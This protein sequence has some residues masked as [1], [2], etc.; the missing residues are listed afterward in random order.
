MRGW[1][2]VFTL[3]AVL[4]VMAAVTIAGRGHGG[5]EWLAAR[6]LPENHRVTRS[7]LQAPPEANT[8]GIH[9]PDP[10]ELEARFVGAQIPVGQAVT[11][12][13]LRAE[14]TIAPSDGDVVY[15]LPLADVKKT[16][17]SPGPGWAVDVCAVDKGCIRGTVVTVRCDASQPP[18][19]AV[20][21]RLP[22]GSETTKRL[23]DKA[24]VLIAV[25]PRQ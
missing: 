6:T 3:Y 12:A 5:R 21:L 16:S 13:N 2:A 11:R 14:P 17:V 8:L 4:V 15:W 9:L 20:G 10:A 24:R 25:S 23:M 1:I 18:A 19:C 7:D 22:E